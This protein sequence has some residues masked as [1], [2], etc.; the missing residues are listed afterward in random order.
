MTDQPNIKSYFYDKVFS[1]QGRVFYPNL[2]EPKQGTHPG[3]R[4]KYS[5][6][7]AWKIGTNQ[8]TTEQLGAF[9]AQAKQTFFPT[10][11]DQYFVNP[12]K[13]YGVY[14]RTDGKPVAE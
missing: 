4:L 12:I 7:I 6:V 8:S 2:L 10:V 11:P 13:K 1:I 3:S 5:C 14:Q 9:L